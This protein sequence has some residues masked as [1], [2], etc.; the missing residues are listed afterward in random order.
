MLKLTS[1]QS[2]TILNKINVFEK[3]TKL[4]FI[5]DATIRFK[6][7]QSFRNIAI[8]EDMQE[9]AQAGIDATPTFIINGVM[10]SGAQ[11]YEKF[12]QI[13][14]RLLAEMKKN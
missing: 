7:L 14:D 11:S 9:A 10:L 12:I 2:E 3:F 13:I 8:E 5:N 6:I 4:S 1:E